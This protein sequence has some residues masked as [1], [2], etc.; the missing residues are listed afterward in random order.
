MTRRDLPPA[1][2]PAFA[3]SRKDSRQVNI[4]DHVIVRVNQFH[5]INLFSLSRLI[6]P[7]FIK[8]G[9]FSGGAKSIEAPGSLGQGRGLSQTGKGS[10]PMPKESRDTVAGPFPVPV[11]DHPTAELFLRPILSGHASLRLV[12]ARASTRFI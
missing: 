8:Y 12:G 9:N 2:S 7:F 5:L 1:S 10:G 4:V 6:C 3:S 11:Y